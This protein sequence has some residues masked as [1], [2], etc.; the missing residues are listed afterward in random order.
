MNI[1]AREFSQIFIS[2]FLPSHLREFTTFPWSEICLWRE[3]EGCSFFLMACQHFFFY[4]FCISKCRAENKIESIFHCLGLT[5]FLSSGT[6][7]K[8]LDA[9]T[10]SFW[11]QT[12]DSSQLLIKGGQ[13]ICEKAVVSLAKTGSSAIIPTCLCWAIKCQQSLLSGMYILTC[14]CPWSQSC[15]DTAAAHFPCYGNRR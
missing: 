5:P 6:M 12:I 3:E 4:V 2:G 1:S 13:K 9:I 11:S 8:S 15:A 7:L 14:Q 10:N